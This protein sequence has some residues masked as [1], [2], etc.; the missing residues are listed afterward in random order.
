[1]KIEILNVGILKIKFLKIGN[2]NVGLGGK[3]T[4]ITLFGYSL[5]I[6]TIKI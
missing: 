1:L 5:S 3:L 4:K 2:L 6:V